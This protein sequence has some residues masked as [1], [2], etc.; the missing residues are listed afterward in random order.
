MT[1]QSLHP[2]VTLAEALG[3]A[4]A[5]VFIIVGAITVVSDIARWHA[6]PGHEYRRALADLGRAVAGRE[7]HR[8]R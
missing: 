4:V 7:V 6:E 8:E 3:M 2:I 1:W 5:L